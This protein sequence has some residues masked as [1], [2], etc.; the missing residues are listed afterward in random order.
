MMCYY[1]YYY[2]YFKSRVLKK[3]QCYVIDLK[4]PKQE[5]WMPLMFVIK[6]ILMP[7]KRWGREGSEP[8]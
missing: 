2:Y 8:K 5:Q 6:G 7:S 3:G 1:C 4:I